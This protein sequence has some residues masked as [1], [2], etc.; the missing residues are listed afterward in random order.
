VRI[1]STFT[2]AEQAEFLGLCL[3][4][5]VIAGVLD[6]LRRDWPLI[7]TFLFTRCVRARC[8]NDVDILNKEL[9]ITILNL[10]DLS[11][12]VAIHGAGE[13]LNLEYRLCGG[14]T[15]LLEFILVKVVVVEAVHGEM[16]LGDDGLGNDILV[17][18]VVVFVWEAGKHCM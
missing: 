15:D 12:L 9:L 18:C 10:S 1:D 8:G 17:V 11:E 4:V 2:L 3:V 16:L 6:I 7:W 5:W 14:F 13:V